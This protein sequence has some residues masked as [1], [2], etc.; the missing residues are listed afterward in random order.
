VL[1][2]RWLSTDSNF[3]E[4]FDHLSQSPDVPQ[5]FVEHCRY[6]ERAGRPVF[7][8][9]FHGRNNEREAAEEVADFAIYMLLGQLKRRRLGLPENRAKAMEAARH[10]AIAWRL[11]WELDQEG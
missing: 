2:D 9:R 4:F 7:G 8:N 11:A 1:D 10:A 6:R 5:A 3:D